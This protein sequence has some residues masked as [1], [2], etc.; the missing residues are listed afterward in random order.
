M[1]H[2]YIPESLFQ[3]IE[4]ALPATGSPDD[5]ILQAVRDRLLLESQR[6]EF[7]RISD[8]MR[9]A[10]VEKGLSEEDLLADFELSRRTEEK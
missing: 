10:M 3:D 1:P 6:R 5:F 7:F 4:K 9:A 8:S 2:V